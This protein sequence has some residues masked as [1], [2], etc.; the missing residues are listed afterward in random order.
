LDL[1]G[2]IPVRSRKRRPAPPGRGRP[3]DP[4]VLR[5]PQDRCHLSDPAD[6]CR[7]QQGQRTTRKRSGFDGCAWFLAADDLPPVQATI[8]PGT[9]SRRIERVDR[10]GVAY[11]KR[12][13]RVSRHTRQKSQRPRRS[14]RECTSG[15]QQFCASANS[16]AQVW[17]GARAG[18]P[19]RCHSTNL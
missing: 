15:A 3:S 10:G 2:V 8:V 11:V 13:R 12:C 18:L 17:R 19:C 6:C 5:G 16:S 14:R 4:P 7:I 9:P 1:R